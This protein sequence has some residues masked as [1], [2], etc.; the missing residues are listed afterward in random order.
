MT[1]EETVKQVREALAQLRW[2]IS[3]G[4]KSVQIAPGVGVFLY[5]NTD[6]PTNLGIGLHTPKGEQ[7]RPLPKGHV[8][9]KGKST[10]FR[11][12]C[13]R[14]SDTGLDF[15]AENTGRLLALHVAREQETQ[16]KP[17]PEA[18]PV[19]A[20][21]AGVLDE[22]AVVVRVKGKEV[23]RFPKGKGWEREAALAVVESIGSFPDGKRRRVNYTVQIGAEPVQPCTVTVE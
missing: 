10:W 23:A 14:L 15:W 9:T 16:A 3:K 22:D 1:T 21:P 7:R 18:K 17:L 20:L 11:D 5:E 12:N 4:S 6:S 13:W 2:S 8:T 19:L